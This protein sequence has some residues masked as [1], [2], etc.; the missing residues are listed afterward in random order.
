M[1]DVHF[2]GR[3]LLDVPALQALCDYCNKDESN[4]LNA[5]AKKRMITAA[6]DGS[7]AGES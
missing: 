5:A 3:Q 7:F 2:V 1:R 4:K 6:G